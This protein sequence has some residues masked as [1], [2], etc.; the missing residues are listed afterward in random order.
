MAGRSHAGGLM[1]PGTGITETVQMFKG[2]ISRKLGSRLPLCLP[3]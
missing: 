3:W 1:A 2:C